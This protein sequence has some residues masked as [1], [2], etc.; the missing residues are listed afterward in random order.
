MSPKWRVSHYPQVVSAQGESVALIN[1]Q[2]IHWVIISRLN[3][4]FLI[5]AH[6][7]LSKL[8]ERILHWLPE[9]HHFFCFANL[10]TNA[11]N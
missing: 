2:F 5:E 1:L 3:D 11:R 6:L 10:R 4:I 8:Y 9:A 7:W